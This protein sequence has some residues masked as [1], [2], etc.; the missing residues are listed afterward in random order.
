MLDY[1]EVLVDLYTVNEN[2]SDLVLFARVYEED[3]RYCFEI[4][5]VHVP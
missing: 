5:S 1:W 4:E 3:Q 2:A